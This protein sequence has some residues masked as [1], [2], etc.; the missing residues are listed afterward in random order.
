MIRLRYWFLGFR[1]GWYDAR[2]LP[3]GAYNVHD[4]VYRAY[5]A[6][7]QHAQYLRDLLAR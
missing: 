2:G 7:W 6:G 4:P 1:A 5:Y 3:A